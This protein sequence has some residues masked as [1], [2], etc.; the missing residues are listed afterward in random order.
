[1]H[2]IPYFIRATHLIF[3][4]IGAPTKVAQSF[5]S[6]NLW[7]YYQNIPHVD[8]IEKKVQPPTSSKHIKNDDW[9]TALT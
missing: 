2:T 8:Y 9:L 1:M 6:Q 3:L 4:M 5:M 7:L